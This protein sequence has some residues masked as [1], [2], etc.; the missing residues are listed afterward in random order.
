MEAM[1]SKTREDAPASILTADSSTTIT[2]KKKSLDHPKRLSDGKDPSFEFWQRAIR[3]KLTVDEHETPTAGEQ[4]D[5]IISRCEGKAAAHVEADLGKGTFDGDPERLI[6][7]LKDLFDHPHRQDRALQQFQRLAMRD[8]E[9]YSDFYLRF[10]K[11][12][13]DAE[14]PESL[15]KAELNQKITRELQFG[16][17]A[18]IARPGISFQEF[19]ASVSRLAFAREGIVARQKARTAPP[20]PASAPSTGPRQPRARKHRTSQSLSKPRA[21][22]RRQHHSRSRDRQVL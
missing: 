17:A 19:Q 21:A 12:A 7:F 6:N 5:Y 2:K 13:A 15:L 16:A 3:H 1:R 22:P 8:G 4:V 9:K 14:L 20:R 18:E 11:L 10:R